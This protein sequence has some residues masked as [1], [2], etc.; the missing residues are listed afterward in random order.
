MLFNTLEFVIF[1]PL[2]LLAYFMLPHR[3]RWI[4]LLA[5]SYYFYMSWKVEYLA[6][7]L[8]STAVDYSA[9]ILME[10]QE[11]RQK[12]L[13]YLLLSLLVNLGLLFTFKYFNFGMENLNLL[14]EKAG[15]SKQIPYH[16]LL[17]PVGISFYTFQTLSYSIDVYMGKQKAERHL[18]YFALYVAFFPQ[19][20]AGPIERYSR[21]S[22]QLKARHA[23]QYA[24]LSNGLRLVLYGLFIKMAVADNLSSLVD[25][26]FADPDVF[27][28]PDLLK[29]IFF[30]S[31]QIYSDFY[32]YS[33]IAIGSALI[34]GIRI[35]D[36]FK[37]PYL[38]K[39]IAEFWQ[40]WHISLSTWFR[41]YLYFPL[42]GNR[43][44]H[45]RWIFNI[46]VVFVV[47]GLWHGANWTF[48]IWGGL[49]GILYLAEKGFNG[50]FQIRSSAPAYSAVHILLAL[51]TFALVTLIWV[52]FRSQSL[53]DAL[54]M[55]ALL[56]RNLG[57]DGTALQVPL[58]TWILLL[59]FI[60]SDIILYDKRFDSW[61]AKRPA[62]L[63]W[64]IYAL[65]IFAILAFAGVEN[66][67]FIYFQ[68]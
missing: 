26:V 52:F 18:G 64:S 40:R 27:A 22:P 7:I 5:A 33:L 20:V 23:F 17:L 54:H 24:N 48:L 35:I 58:I 10:K 47:S 28:T 15:I 60:I 12:R 44:K 42:G 65:L 25:R 56:Y 4:L 2:V 68:F 13:P 63:R 6:L 46:L 36:N 38:A 32:G 66:H 8:A 9:G 53:G 59:F 51:K 30:Y 1:L 16:N 19:L 62:P 45:L 14:L 55:F 11:K 61:V 31:F 67:P 37:T 29:G 39:N 57:L 50:L 21:L 3:L 49:F 34:M 41:D 43:V